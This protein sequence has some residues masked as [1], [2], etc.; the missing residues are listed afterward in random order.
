MWVQYI[1]FFLSLLYKR[2]YWAILIVFCNGD[3]GCS[4]FV[5]NGLWTLH[6]GRW[7]KDS[8]PA[9]LAGWSKQH[10][11]FGK[12]YIR[13]KHRGLCLKNRPKMNRFLLHFVLMT[14][15]GAREI[16]DFFLFRGLVLFKLKTYQVWAFMGL[17]EKSPFRPAECLRPLSV[18]YHQG[19]RSW[20]SAKICC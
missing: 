17:K 16:S 5:G 13:K 9:G 6:E 8:P 10:S 4:Q 18:W 12:K 14:E 1:P 19:F 15:K 3:F 2:P 7:T 11:G 20:I